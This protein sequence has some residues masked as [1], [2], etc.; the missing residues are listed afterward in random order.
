[1]VS[2]PIVW[3]YAWKSKISQNVFRPSAIVNTFALFSF[4][5]CLHGK[6]CHQ[7]ETKMALG[8]C[9]N[10]ILSVFEKRNARQWFFASWPCSLTF[11]HGITFDFPW[12]RCRL[13]IA[14]TVPIQRNVN[15][16]YAGVVRTVAYRHQCSL[17]HSF[18]PI[19]QQ[20]FFI[21][22]YKFSLVSIFLLSLRVS[23]TISFRLWYVQ[24]KPIRC[25]RLCNC[26]NRTIHFLVKHSF[27]LYIYF[28]A[29]QR[30]EVQLFFSPSFSSLL[31]LGTWQYGKRMTRH[32]AH[33]HQF[34]L[35]YGAYLLCARLSP[36]ELF[37]FTEALKSFGIQSQ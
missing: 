30:T 7:Q 33:Y 4:S 25:L 29:W 35:K 32:M 8:E 28:C 15:I 31:V 1:M 10:T 21:H 13:A 12:N 27:V 37:M 23:R 20:H 17:F 16:Y 26:T 18:I 9:E 36:K 11:D 34:H 5:H 3:C 22:S 14:Q 6:F 2:N 24:V 19:L